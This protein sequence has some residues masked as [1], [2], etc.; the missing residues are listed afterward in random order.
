MKVV[1]AVDVACG[2]TEVLPGSGR[3]LAPQGTHMPVAAPPAP[4][5]PSEP[6]SYGD[7]LWSS[8]ARGSGGRAAGAS[9]APKNSPRLKAARPAS[10]RSSHLPSSAIAPDRRSL[11]G[12]RARGVDD[13]Q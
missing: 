10:R 5:R 9:S 11:D 6:G 13:G 12:G 2:T 8:M 4:E 3:P 1:P 7:S